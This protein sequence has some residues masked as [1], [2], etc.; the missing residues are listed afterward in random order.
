MAEKGNLIIE[1]GNLMIPD[2]EPAFPSLS[3]SEAELFERKIKERYEISDYVDP[4][5]PNGYRGWRVY[6][7]KNG[8]EVIFSPN[9]RYIT[10]KEYLRK[11]ENDNP[12]ENVLDLVARVAVNIATA[13]RK[14]NP[15]AD[16]MPVAER[17]VQR[18]IYREFAP[19]TPTFANAGGHLQQLAAC[20]GMTLEDYLGTD[21]IGEDVEKQGNGI[22]D[23]LR[24]GA[25][26]QK[27]GGGTGYN[28]SY[29]RPKN[30]GIAT[31]GGRASGPCSWA[32]AF[33]SATKEINQGGFRRGANM[34]ILEYW[35]PDIFEFLSLKVDHE[36]P[37][38]NFSMGVDE[39]FMD[40]VENNVFFYL[41][42]PKDMNKTPLEQR[43]WTSDKLIKQSEFEKMDQTRK[44]DL[45][46]SLLL[47]N[48]G[49][50]IIVR[51]TGK[52]VGFVDE[53]GR[54]N[55]SARATME[56]AA[57]MA[58][59]TGCPGIIFFD[60]MNKENP[61]P[62]I[63]RIRV[64]N[65]CG[66]QPLLDFEAC[67]LGSVNTYSCVED[68]G[69]SSQSYGLSIDGRYF[70]GEVIAN[71][72]QKR[73]D[74]E[75]F[76][77]IIDDGIHFL[78][79]VIDMGKYPFKKIYSRVKSNRKVGLG[80]MGVAETAMALGIDYESE[81]MENFAKIISSYISRRALKKSQEL[82]KERGVFPNWGRSIYDPES[83][84]AQ[85][86]KTGHVRNAT[87]ITIAPNGTTGRYSDVNGGI[88]PM[89]AAYSHKNLADGVR[90][91]YSNA[92]F[93]DEL[94]IRGLYNEEL[95]EKIKKKK[96]LQGIE[97]I[98]EDMQRRYKFA[99]EVDPMW[100]IRI[101]AAFQ[102]GD[103]IF[104]VENAVSKTVNLPENSTPKTF[105]D[106]FMEAGRLGCK[107]I[108]A[109]RQGTIE[110][111]PLTIESIE[112]KNL[113]RI[114][115]VNVPIDSPAISIAD[116]SIKYRIARK[117]AN[118][119]ED[120]F[121]VVFTDEFRKDPKSGKVYSFP[122]EM[123]QQTAPPGDEISVEFTVQGID[124]TNILKEEDPDY[125]K[126]IE[127]WKSVTGNRSG[128]L[129]PTRINSPSHGVGLVFEHAMLS[130]GI[131]DYNKDTGQLFQIIRKK[132]TLPLTENEKKEIFGN[133]DSY[134]KQNIT[135]KKIF[136]FLCPDCGSNEYLFE[137]GCHEPKC[138]ECSWSK[139]GN[140]S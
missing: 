134:T 42:T 97:E 119:D 14:Y 11:D 19:N 92:L 122:R 105:F 4:K 25:M 70:Y 24:Y 17:F 72:I 110:G 43:I 67:N 111:Q 131:V 137:Q 6:D 63:G 22:F 53:N 8:N 47:S 54:I 116:N 52:E 93:E 86:E 71:K 133:G 85:K 87:R 49:K 76:G 118:G 20:F 88:E 81:E 29:T 23:I 15:K 109:Y 130:R 12:F 7:K 90:L 98:P 1:K 39:G 32:K 27:S 3:H 51:Y 18:M 34:G 57:E 78:D 33:N 21:D 123:F 125:V 108:T 35:H 103:G 30:S 84:N 138:R 91:E 38:F 73:I 80:L 96:T 107:G 74:L 140:C 121:H 136:W 66:E 41:I 28:F 55:I 10:T 26:I 2:Y 31:T 48:D 102:V 61:T 95:V 132:D 135:N 100:H 64:V 101:Q 129:G 83:P 65:P 113:E 127:R 77:E 79:N 13:E 124:R 117:K 99:T 9:A 40:K 120:V 59:R 139:T 94:K 69:E 68:V 62:H 60:K 44:E 128:G 126:L 46:P 45:D 82:G 104:G 114:V 56:Y 115:R 5:N 37:F 58:W 50:N 75:K 16:I 112:K 36:L 106:I 89:F